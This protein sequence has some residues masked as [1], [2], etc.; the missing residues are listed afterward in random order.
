MSPTCKVIVAGERLSV[1][2]EATVTDATYGG[3]SIQG[4]V[5]N[6]EKGKEG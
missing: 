2:T 4:Q 5:K 1:A 3:E 6:Y